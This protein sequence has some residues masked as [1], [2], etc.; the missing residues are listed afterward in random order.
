MATQPNQKSLPVN[1]S[2]HA[3][4]QSAQ[5]SSS[6]ATRTGTSPRGFGITPQEFFTTTNPF[7]LLRRM[8]EEMDRAFHDFGL[9]PGAGSGI[10]WA[11]AIEVSERDGQYKVRAE[12]PGLSPDDVKVEVSNRTLTIQGERSEERE[13]TDKNVYRSERQY[14]AFYRTVPLPEGADV[15][16]ANAKFDNGLLE[17]SVPVPQQKE[18]RR[19]IPVQGSSPGRSQTRAA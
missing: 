16:H 9:N 8:T 12:L 5:R 11:P 2:E 7:S 13:Q 3:T 18:D 19:S 10:G 17:V 1:A 15:E 4:G 6:L 14:G